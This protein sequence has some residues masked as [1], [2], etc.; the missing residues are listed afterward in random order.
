MSRASTTLK[1]N[2]IPGAET[3]VESPTPVA[4]RRVDVVFHLLHRAGWHLPLD[5]AR[6]CCPAVRVVRDLYLVAVNLNLCLRQRA[7]GVANSPSA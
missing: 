4:A 7:S 2:E 3:A 1:S 6:A 5:F